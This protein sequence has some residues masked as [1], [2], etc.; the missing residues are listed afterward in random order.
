MRVGK[1]GKTDGSGRK[2]NADQERVHRH[3]AEII[4]P[5]PPAPN[6]LGSSGS[7]ELP[8]RHHGKYAA[9]RAQPDI[10]LICEQGVAH[11]L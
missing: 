6:G 10:L 7:D 9:K 1:E 5:S 4:G 3:N 2:E 8:N 11:D